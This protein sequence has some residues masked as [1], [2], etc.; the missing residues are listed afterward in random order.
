MGYIA[1]GRTIN[2]TRQ[3]RSVRGTTENEARQ[4]LR[5]I[6]AELILGR[7]VTDG[8]IRLAPFLREWLSTTIEPNCLS[9]N[10]AASYRGIVERHLI[11]SLGKIRLRDITVLD[12]DHLLHE[13]YESGLSASTVQRIRMILVKALRHAER[14]ISYTATSPHLQIYVA[15]RDVKVG[16]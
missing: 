10:T 14:E 16:R 8:T 13:K 7:P 1:T 5:E 3:R 12:V 9:I 4:K 15:P 11:P 6:E 2:G